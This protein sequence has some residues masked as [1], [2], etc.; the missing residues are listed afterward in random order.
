M[1]ISDLEQETKILF[2]TYFFPQKIEDQLFLPSVKERVNQ[3]KPDLNL[4][5]SLQC[6]FLF[7][8]LQKFLRWKISRSFRTAK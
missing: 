6:S 5:K 1:A 8:E 7:Y 4:E 3:E 2:R